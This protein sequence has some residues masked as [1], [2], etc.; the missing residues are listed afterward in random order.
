MGK[1]KILGSSS[2]GN[3]YVLECGGE[4]L[5]IEW[6]I[7]WP[8]LVKAL[9]YGKNFSK[10]I[11]CL[12]THK[13]LDHSK[14]VPQALEHRLRVFSCKETKE[15]YEGVSVL[16]AGK[17]YKIGSFL[18]MPLEVEHS[19]QCYSYLIEHKDMGR[20]LFATDLESFPYHLKNINH[21]FVE[22]NYSDDILIDNHINDEEGKSHPENH[23]SYDD[24]MEVIRTNYSSEIQNIVM[25][26]L[27]D[28]NSDADKF[29]QGMIDEFV[30][31]NVFIADE[32]MELELKD[33]EF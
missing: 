9:D 10:I 33:S 14:Y 12:V 4:I 8:E 2:K 6:G 11:G 22:A 24:C 15:Q 32:G 21:F 29:R 13:H 31:D 23:L 16:D 30:M 3:C 25:I 7:K 26:H 28:R 20:M 27:S 18:V 1:I 5:I 17:K 19:C